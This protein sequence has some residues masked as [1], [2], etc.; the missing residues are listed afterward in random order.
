MKVILA[1]TILLNFPFSTLSQYGG[2]FEPVIE[3]AVKEEL[4][5]FKIVLEGDTLINYGDTF[6][7]TS[8]SK[9]R[10]SYVD[11]CEKD[12]LFISIEYKMF[13]KLKTYNSNNYTASYHYRFN[14]KLKNV[15]I[16]FSELYR[17]KFNI[18]YKEI[19]GKYF[20]DKN[21]IVKIEIINPYLEWK[22][23][24]FEIIY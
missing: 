12:S 6:I 7:E 17:Q 19:T 23:D 8:F 15:S 18:Q 2:L 9:Y 3:N 21:R 5:S 22:V 13:G 16:V 24:S 4:V 14:G 10:Y 1:L 11:Y 20:H